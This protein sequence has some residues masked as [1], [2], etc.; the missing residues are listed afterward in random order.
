MFIRFLNIFMFFAAVLAGTKVFAADA[1]QPVDVRLQ[2]YQVV[3]AT[4]DAAEKLVPATVAN[5]GDTIEYQVTYQ[6]NGK[7]PAK[8]VAATLPVPEGAM[9]YLDGSA[10][11]KAVQASLD[12]KQFSPIPLTREVTRAGKRVIETVPPAEYRFLRWELG[13]LAPG[14]A[15]TVTSRMRVA[16]ARS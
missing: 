14:K 11:P 13:D 12:G 16:G 9:A 5:P 8:A 3:A 6:N 4:K 1:A 10:A 7:L 2:A 15:A